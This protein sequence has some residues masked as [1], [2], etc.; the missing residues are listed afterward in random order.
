MVRYVFVVHP[1]RGR[2]ILISTDTSL[3]PID[4]VI[5][6]GF[7]F[8]IE[9]AFKQAIYLVGAFGYH[10]WMKTMNKIK[11]CSSDQYLH[12]ETERY[13]QMVAR[14]LRAY[15]VYMQYGLIALGLMQFLA[16]KYPRQIYGS[17]SGWYRTLNTNKTPSEA[18][19]A[20]GLKNSFP[21]FITN[22]PRNDILRKFLAKWISW[23]GRLPKKV[24][25]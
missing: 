23:M 12:R 24:A 7:R 14:K 4:I 8:R 18:V 21:E 1:T 2:W 5:T 20:C 13:R 6:Y 11:R 15:E 3:L 25:A 19:V 16:L 22:L 17:F 9:L 10:L